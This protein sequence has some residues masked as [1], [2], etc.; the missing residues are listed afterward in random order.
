VGNGDLSLPE[1]IWRAW[2]KGSSIHDLGDV[3]NRLRTTMFC[4]KKWSFE[5][6]GAV[7]KEIEN[8]RIKM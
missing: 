3:A 1:E 8:I 2:S 6:F 4:L 5:K 7:T